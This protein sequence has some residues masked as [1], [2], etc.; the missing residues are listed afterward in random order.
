MMTTLGA[1]IQ[2]DPPQMAMIRKVDEESNNELIIED[3]DDRTCLVRENKVEEI[4]QRVKDIMDKAMGGG[5]EDEDEE[6]DSDLG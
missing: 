3:I 1:L 6:K 2:C 5:E 4:K